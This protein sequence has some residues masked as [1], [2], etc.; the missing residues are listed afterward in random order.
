MGN[1]IYEKKEFCII[2]MNHHEFIVLNRNK[3]F[4]C[5]HTHINN[6]NTAKHIL[7][8]AV[9]ESIPHHLSLYL[10][11]SLVRISA[12]KNYQDKIEALLHEKKSRSKQN[13]RNVAVKRQISAYGC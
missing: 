12:N 13:Y 1:V 4:K 7:N 10:L 9:H 2:Q 11:T 8:L 5:G 3:E 6:Y